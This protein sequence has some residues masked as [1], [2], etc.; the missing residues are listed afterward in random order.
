MRSCPVA[1]L[2]TVCVLSAGGVGLAQP[3]ATWTIQGT[4]TDYSVTSYPATNPARG[5]YSYSVSGTTVQSY[6]ADLYENLDYQASGANAAINYDIKSLSVGFDTSFFYF[7]TTVNGNI[8]T[9]YYYFEIDS[10]AETDAS[11]RPDYFL[12]LQPS[13]GVLASSTWSNANVSS[14]FTVWNDTNTGN[15]RIGGNN[16]LN[17]VYDQNGN[18]IAGQVGGSYNTSLTLSATNLY[19]RVLSVANTTTDD[20]YLDVAVRRSFINLP[21]SGTAVASVRALASQSSSIANDKVFIHDWFKPSDLSG[22]GFDNTNSSDV[23]TWLRVGE[24]AGPVLAVPTLSGTVV[25]FGNFRV[26]ATLTQTLTLVNSMSAA[27]STSSRRCMR[28]HRITRRRTRSVSAARSAWLIGRVAR[29]AGGASPPASAAAGTKTP[30]VTHSC[31][32]TWRLSAEPKRCRKEM[33]PSR[34]RAD[35]GVAA[36]L[37][38]PAA[39]HSSRSISSR[40]IFVSAAT[41]GGRSASMPRNRFGTEI[42]HCRTGTGGTT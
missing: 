4:V 37:M 17:P 8:S 32:C 29:N 35:A 10:Q 23:S 31:R 1:C 13:A 30:S 38:T 11:R 9:G 20:G 28:N 2:A 5:Q 21:P 34:G 15:S 22:L 16:V 42:T 14:L 12:Q 18:T 39:A 6:V 26:G 19:Y 27:A 7:R 24:A 36:S 3:S 40:K 41:A 25:N 33:P